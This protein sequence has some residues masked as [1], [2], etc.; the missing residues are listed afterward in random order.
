M[1]APRGGVLNG[2]ELG[3]LGSL[4]EHWTKV[5]NSDTMGGMPRRGCKSVEALMVLRDASCSANTGAEH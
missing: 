1:S 5:L 3:G 4:G 2:L